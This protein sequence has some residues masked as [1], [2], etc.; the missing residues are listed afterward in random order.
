MGGVPHRVPYKGFFGVGGGDLDGFFSPLV[1]DVFFG[2]KGGSRIFKG[3]WGLESGY[4]G[5]GLSRSHGG[6]RGFDGIGAIFALPFPDK[7]GLAKVFR[8]G[9]SFSKGPFQG[10]CQVGGGFWPQH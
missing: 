3:E 4:W 10:A 2:G 1:G 7:D 9:G 6:S 5:Q 8:P